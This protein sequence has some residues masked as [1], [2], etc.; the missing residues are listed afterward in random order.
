MKDKWLVTLLGY[1]GF[2]NLGDELLALSAI[3]QLEK[4]GISRDKIM[5][6]TASPDFYSKLGVDHVD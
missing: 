4:S 1:Y 5:V 3:N 2:G 6:L